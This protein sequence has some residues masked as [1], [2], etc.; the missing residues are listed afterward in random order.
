[1]LLLELFLHVAAAFLTALLKT[2]MLYERCAPVA[3]IE[4][5]Q[6]LYFLPC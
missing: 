2:Q 1:M 6:F 4:C 5:H 3:L